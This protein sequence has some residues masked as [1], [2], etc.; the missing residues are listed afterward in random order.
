MVAPPI[1][2]QINN[3]DEIRIDEQLHRDHVNPSNNEGNGK[4]WVIVA[5]WSLLAS[6]ISL[7]F[8][9]GIQSNKIDNL[10]N[11]IMNGTEPAP[12]EVSRRLGVLEERQNNN[13]Q[14][15]NVLESQNMYQEKEIEALMHRPPK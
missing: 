9:V 3:D 5:S 11:M 15:M 4:N 1:G 12:S 7:A 10:N 2:S 8:W 6:V 13:I 14:R